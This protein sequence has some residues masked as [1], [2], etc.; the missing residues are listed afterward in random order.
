MVLGRQVAQESLLPSV[1]EDEFGE[2]ENI[3]EP[4]GGI[5][6]RPPSRPRKAYS[7]GSIDYQTVTRSDVS[8]EGWSSR[9]WRDPVD[10]EEVQGRGE[11]ETEGGRQEEGRRSAAANEDYDTDLEPEGPDIRQ[12]HDLSAQARYIEACKVFKVIPSS[13][14]LRNLHNTELILTHHG[15]GTQGTKALA[16]PLVT[17]TTIL[18]LNL[19]DNWLEGLGGVAVAEMLKENCYITDIDLSEN[20]LGESGAKAL[21]SMLLENTTLLTLRLSGNK[22]TDKAAKHL[23]LAVSRNQK[24]ESLD[25]GYNKLGETAGEVLGDAI[26]EN[27][28]MKSLNLAWNCIRGRGAVALAKGLRANIFLQ[29]LDLS[30]NGL[31]KDGAIAVGEA[32]RD[33]N[34]LEE[35]DISNNRIPPEGAIRL[36]MGLKMS[37]N[38]MQSVGCYG[39]LQSIQSNQDSAVEY[40]DLSDIPVDKDFYDLCAKVKD[41]LPNIQVKHGRIIDFSTRKPDST[42]DGC[43]NDG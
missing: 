16:V 9:D 41:T 21:S 35:L 43:S 13:H 40:L 14:V 22:L 31:E 7:R 17:N 34:T 36:A 37:R 28:G 4:V 18:K 33:N 8:S 24:L 32:L 1:L 38:P 12:V 11:V 19:K 2:A 25:L 10:Q 20:R 6:S 29:K 42:K 39:V 30:Y 15:L 26:A 3:K 23:A 27:A 5:G